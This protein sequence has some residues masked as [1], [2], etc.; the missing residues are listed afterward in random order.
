MQPDHTYRHSIELNAKHH[1]VPKPPWMCRIV[2]LQRG[3]ALASL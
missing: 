1:E 3:G 2:I